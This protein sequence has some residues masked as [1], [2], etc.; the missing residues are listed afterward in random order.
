MKKEQKE[1]FAKIRS[2]K[3]KKLLCRRVLKPDSTR[4]YFADSWLK[5]R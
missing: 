2:E 1:N 5:N 3:T 4:S